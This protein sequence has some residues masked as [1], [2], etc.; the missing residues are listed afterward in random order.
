MF[1]FLL[2]SYSFYVQ[3]HSHRYPLFLYQLHQLQNRLH[4]SGVQGIS[5]LG[6][7]RTVEVTRVTDLRSFTPNE[8]WCDEFQSLIVKLKAMPSKQC[9]AYVFISF[10]HCGE[11]ITFYRFHVALVP[12]VLSCEADLHPNELEGDAMP[13]AMLVCAHT[14]LKSNNLKEFGITP[15]LKGILLQP[16]CEGDVPELTRSQLLRKL[17]DT[18]AGLKQTEKCLDARILHQLQRQYKEFAKPR[19]VHRVPPMGVAMALI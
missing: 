3:F 5:T 4:S 12:Q 7:G 2:H 6:D 17:K 10:L 14:E 18:P 13:K 11:V 16:Q 19:T 8:F 9:Q 15:H 1:D